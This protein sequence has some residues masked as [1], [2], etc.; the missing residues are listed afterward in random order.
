MM[1]KAICEFVL[2]KNVLAAQALI[3]KCRDDSDSTWRYSSAFLHAYQGK[4]KE[5]MSDY[6]K[7]FKGTVADKSVPIQCE[8][9]IQS[10]LATDP[11]CVQ[12]HFCL[13]LINYHAKEDFA[14]A[15][16][17]FGK[18]LS[19]VKDGEFKSVAVKAQELLGD[20]KLKLSQNVLAPSDGSVVAALGEAPAPTPSG[21]RIIV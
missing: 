2:R 21:A 18:F 16:E 12:L 1:V 14:V 7:A 8:G 11:N 9:F 20:C 10:V 4:M 5:A 19:M 13:G 17:D 3:T 6:R 15:A